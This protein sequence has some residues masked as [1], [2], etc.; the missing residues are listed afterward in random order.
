MLA[1]RGRPRQSGCAA[2][3]SPRDFFCPW[4]GEQIGFAQGVAGEHVGDLHDLLL[5]DDDSQGLLEHGFEFGEFVSD[6][7]ATPLALDEVV[8]HAALD[9]AGTV[10][11]VEGGEIFYRTGL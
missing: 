11:R 10:E 3:P 7:A 2:W 1:L 9:G 6:D 8:D 5:V 4:R